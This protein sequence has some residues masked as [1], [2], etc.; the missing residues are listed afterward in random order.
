MGYG[1]FLDFSVLTVPIILNG[2]FQIYHSVAFEVGLGASFM[3]IGHQKTESN[4]HWSYE[5]SIVPTGNIGI[6]VQAK[7]GFLLRVDFTPYYTD[8]KY[9]K[10]DNAI[11]P[12]FGLSL[13]YSFGKK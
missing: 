11:I 7:N 4:D 8:L 13:G 5:N 9:T 10:T 1:Q 3:R 2:I 6:R 12:S